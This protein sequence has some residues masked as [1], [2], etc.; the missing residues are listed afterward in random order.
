M[1]FPHV[2]GA[3][4]GRLEKLRQLGALRFQPPAIHM[5][6]GGR[7][8]LTGLET[9]PRGGADGLGSDGFAKEGALARKAIQM[10]REAHGV[11]VQA[12]SIPTLLIG[13]EDD[14]VHVLKGVNASPWRGAQTTSTRSIR[15]D[16]A[17]TPALSLPIHRALRPLE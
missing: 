3:I 8:V 10:G 14:E 11:S 2:P 17:D 7:R 6:S 16:A 1:P 13:E 9:T 15:P 12:E 5:D 4:T